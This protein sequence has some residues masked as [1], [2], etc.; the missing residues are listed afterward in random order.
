MIPMT[1]F[2]RLAL[3]SFVV[4]VVVLASGQLW[5]GGAVSA[6]V[7]LYALGI[8]VVLTPLLYWW[9]VRPTAQRAVEAVHHRDLDALT[10][11]LNQHGIT[12]ELLG[13]MARADRYDNRL[14]VAIVSIDHAADIVREYGDAAHDRCVQTVAEVLTEA[15]RMPDRVGRY[16]DGHFLAILPETSMNGACQ[17]AERIRRAVATTAVEVARQ[18]TIGLTVSIG[19][20]GF[21]RGEDLE[22]LLGRAGRAL[23]QAR[24][25]GH[26]RVLTDL[27][28]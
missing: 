16:E 15:I 24:D 18:Q 6:S 1:V 2:T 4:P 3:L 14:S 5:T 8:T 10:D 17:I 28:A 25:Q 12:V 19:V 7:L 26:N 27:A 23:T 22:Q 21:R 11:T 13:V 9:V 20:T